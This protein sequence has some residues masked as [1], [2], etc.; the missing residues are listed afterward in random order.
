MSELSKEKVE[1]DFKRSANR[2]NMWNMQTVNMVDF[3]GDAH[4]NTV[5][6]L[7]RLRLVDAQQ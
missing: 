6:K 5:T 7:F 3:Q 1:T 4:I 2:W